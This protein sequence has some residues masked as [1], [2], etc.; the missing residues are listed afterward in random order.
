VEGP[1]A[2]GPFTDTLHTAKGLKRAPDSRINWR[3]AA[4]KSSPE[5]GRPWWQPV[6][7]TCTRSWLLLCR[8]WD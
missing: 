5:A 7:P 6:N 3:L 2:P 4:S 8:G 1:R